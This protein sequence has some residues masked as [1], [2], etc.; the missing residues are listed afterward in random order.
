MRY[1]ILVSV[2]SALLLA[3]PATAAPD[4]SKKIRRA[5]H[6][7]QERKEI[8]LLQRS[9]ELYWDGVRWN[10]A[11]K[12]STFVEDPTTRM[13]FQQWLEDRFSSQRVM[14]A[15]VLRVDV[16]PPLPKESPEARKALISV[17][18]EGYTLPEQ[19]VKN[20]VVNQVWYRSATGW[21]LEWTPPVNTE[22]PT[23]A[24]P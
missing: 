17:S 7:K 6:V 21:W 18:V 15:R 20:E 24:S 23:P 12:S 14:N 22:A 2:L 4:Q 1:S 16:G 8:E 19:V 9:T 11:E 5:K 3:L 13:Q 10:N